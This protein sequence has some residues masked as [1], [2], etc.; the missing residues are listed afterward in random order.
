MKS[1]EFRKKFLSYFHTQGHTIVP[2]SSVIPHEDSTLLFTNAGMNQ[3][4]DVFLGTSK[5]PYSRATTAQ[6]CIRAGGKHND[7]ENVGHTSRHLTFFEMLGNFSFGDYFKQEAIGYAWDL[8]THVWG[9]DVQKIWVSVYKDDDEAFALWEHHLPASRIV[10]FGE[11]ENFWTMGD[12]GP[13]GPCSELLYDRGERYGSA[14]SPIEDLAGERFFEFWNLVFMQYNRT[15]NGVMELLPTPSIDT[16][17]GLERVVSLAMGVED[18]FLTDILR[19]LIGAVEALSKKTY[20]KNNPLAPAFHVIADHIRSL[21]FA[22]ADGTQPSNTDR[23]YVLRKILRRSVRYGRQLGLQ[24]PFMAELLPALIQLMG[25]DY[26][27]LQANRKR[28]EEILTS[29]EEAFLR[30][31]QRGGNLLSQ[32][33]ERSRGVATIAGDDAF[34]LK[35]T[36]GLPLEE[37]QLIARDEGLVVDLVRFEHLEEEARERSRKARKQQ[38]QQFDQNF[39]SDFARVHQCHF[40]GYEHDH[41]ESLLIGIVRGGCFVDQMQEGEEGILIL[42]RTPFY[43]EQGGQVGDRGQI[44]HAKALFQVEDCLSPYP[45]VIVHL[46]ALLKGSLKKG[47]RIQAVIDAERRKE[48]RC[49]HTATHLLHYALRSILG[50]HVKQAGSLVEDKRLRFDFT[51]HKI[52]TERELRD[53]EDLVNGKV[54]ANT[55]VQIYELF[56]RDVQQRSD[57]QQWFEEKYGE[58]VRVVDIDVSKELCGGTHAP[59]TGSIGLFKIVK[60]GSIAAGV[61]RIE[62]V[63]GRYAEQMVQQQEDLLRRVAEQLKTTPRHVPEQL[64]ELIEEHHQLRQERDRLYQQKLQQMARQLMDRKEQ[65]GSISLMITEVALPFEDLVFFTNELMQ[66]LRS[67]VVVVGALAGDHCQLL[68]QLSPDV[69]LHAQVLIKEVAPLIKGG[70]GGKQTFAQAGGKDPRGLP[71]AFAAIREHVTHVVR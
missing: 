50:S 3:F 53:I 47:D 25:G 23:G 57:I 65:I 68:I 1:Q 13:C 19:A 18:L 42:D 59:S 43:A 70:G 52:V 55:P 6:K 58:R 62:A 44:M 35:D 40:E 7:L 11:K 63:T 14:R 61:R 33:I 54:R 12:V 5:R 37:V 2:S 17:A 8:V 16:G 36:Y 69:P 64:E 48:I 32:V 28:I 56:Y 26:P 10:R 29:E 41:L 4:K 34:L 39:F 30:T 60:E 15:A 31:L 9:L 71:K 38:I 21:S 27:E 46:G 51:H 49:N 45:G 20:E 24:R 22:I 67:G 66:L